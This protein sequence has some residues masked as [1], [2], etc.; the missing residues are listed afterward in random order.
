MNFDY[1]VFVATGN[2]T[3]ALNV[4]LDDGWIPIREIPNGDLGWLILLE[5]EI[6]LEVV[7]EAKPAPRVIDQLQSVIN[8]AREESICDEDFLAELRKL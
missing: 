7:Q 6:V 2:N 8:Q 4:L 3:G 1:K 5:R